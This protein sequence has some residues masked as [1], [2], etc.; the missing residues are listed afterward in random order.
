[1]STP[2]IDAHHHF[3]HYTPEEYG[4]IDDSMSSLRRDFLPEDLLP[5]IQRC[6]MNG[7]ISVQARQTLEET[8]WLLDL[9]AQH[10]FIRG[11]VGWAPLTEGNLQDILDPLT[12]DQKLKGLRHVL[13][14]EPDERYILRDDFNRGI[15]L[16]KQRELVYDI[17]VFERHLSHVIQFVKRHPDQVFVLDHIAKP[18]IRDGILSPWREQMC[19]L[20]EFPNVFCKLSGMVT[21]ADYRTWNEQDLQPYFDTVLNAFGPSRLLFGSDWPVCLAAASY[22]TWCAIVTK[23]IAA[24]TQSQQAAI[25][26]G[27]AARVYRL[28][29]EILKT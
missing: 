21:E 4:W 26:G 3:W 5:E 8:R 10:D 1:M 27:T 2:K 14:A 22:Q 13:Q 6:G 20:A 7:V 11:V 25:M 17:L 18:R 23:Q 15:E 28:Q 16:L 9:A 19:A 29:E 24:L 12:Q